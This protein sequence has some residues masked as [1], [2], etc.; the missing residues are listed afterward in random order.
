MSDGEDGRDGLALSDPDAAY[1][2]A[3]AAVV[4]TPDDPVAR[5][6]AINGIITMHMLQVDGTAPAGLGVARAA[7]SRE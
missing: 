5:A 2:R 4:D 7:R 1:E 3:V 6:A